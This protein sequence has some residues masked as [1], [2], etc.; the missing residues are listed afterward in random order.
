ML[1]QTSDLS[2]VDSQLLFHNFDKEKKQ[3]TEKWMDEFS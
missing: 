1:C 2:M 3:M